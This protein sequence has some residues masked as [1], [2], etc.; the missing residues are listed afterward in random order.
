ML[1]PPEPV[2]VPGHSGC[3]VNAAEFE[4]KD[5]PVRGGPGDEGRPEPPRVLCRGGVAG[6]S[7]LQGPQAARPCLDRSVPPPLSL[8]TS[9]P[10]RACPGSTVLQPPVPASGPGNLSRQLHSVAML[11][12]ACPCG[13]GDL[14]AYNLLNQGQIPS[15]HVRRLPDGESPRGASLSTTQD[16]DRRAPQGTSEMKLNLGQ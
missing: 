16:Y 10:S 7:G 15:E 5:E 9:C 8:P 14:V 13:H 3:S 11:T 12:R 6:G 2:S 4:Q 1:I